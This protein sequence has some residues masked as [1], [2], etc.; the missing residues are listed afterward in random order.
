M[1]KVWTNGCFDV[2]HRGHIESLRFA[3]SLGDWLV[4]GIDTDERV[5]S[6]KGESRPH[7]TLSD[8]IAVL[9]SIKYVDEVRAFSSDEE[10]VSIVREVSPAFFV[11]GAEYKGKR[12]IGS[13]HA[14]QMVY[15]DMKEGYSTTD[16]LNKYGIK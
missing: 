6:A 9:E 13:E 3:K 7:N 16:T 14:L 10:L 1:K 4:I 5:R 8:R 12:V 2:I 11:K 15:F